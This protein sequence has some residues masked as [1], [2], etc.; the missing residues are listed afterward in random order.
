[1]ITT[2]ARNSSAFEASLS[3]QGPDRGPAAQGLSRRIPHQGPDPGGINDVAYKKL[4][5][6][7]TNTCS[8]RRADR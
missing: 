8:T 3:G 6:T 7:Y 2:A 1:M 4:A 5:R